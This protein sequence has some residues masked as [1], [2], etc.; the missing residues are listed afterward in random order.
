MKF[1]FKPAALLVLGL[2]ATCG[3]AAYAQQNT[4]MGTGEAPATTKR[5][6]D[7]ANMDLSVKPGDDF[8]KYA[9][10]NWIKNNPVPA[11]ETRW[12]S[13]NVLREFNNQAVKNILNESEKI[14]SAP[15]G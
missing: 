11:K 1:S 6:I 7:R 12:G 5:Y 3:P 14:S 15:A 4:A 2:A 13:F 8:Y 9:S 10:G